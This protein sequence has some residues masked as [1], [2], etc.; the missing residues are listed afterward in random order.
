MFTKCQGLPKLDGPVPDKE[1]TT[2][3]A[4]NVRG[5]SAEYL[6]DFERMAK[7]MPLKDLTDAQ[8]LT[9]IAQL[10]TMIVKINE[11]VK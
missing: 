5:T 9:L 7:N 1:M 3:A 4:I 6:A 2:S 8:M 11:V 10:M